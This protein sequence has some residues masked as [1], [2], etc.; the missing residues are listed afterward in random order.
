MI[1]EKFWLAIAFLTFILLMYKYARSFLIK[2]IDDKAKL[3]SDEI[4]LAKNARIKAEQALI[5]AENFLKESKDF[6]KK[7]ISDAEKEANEII[8]SSERQVED[9]I[10]K[11][12]KAAIARIEIEEKRAIRD[13]KIDLVEGS[14][15]YFENNIANEVSL[16]E[17]QN[18]NKNSS[19]DLAKL[20]D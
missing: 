2:A 8:K 9:E 19:D 6:G 16:K 1:N 10:S 7:L 4:T 12:T 15:N 13:F 17:S 14:I 18:F 20:I 11:K 3:I 5:Q